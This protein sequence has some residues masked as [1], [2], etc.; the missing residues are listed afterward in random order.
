MKS[1]IYYF[2][3]FCCLSCS[4]L[5]ESDYDLAG[6]EYEET[7]D[8]LI[9]EPN[10]NSIGNGIFF[11]PGGLVD[12][13]AYINTFTAFVREHNMSIIILKVRS[14]LAIINRNQIRNVL[15]DFYSKKWLIG[16]HSLGGSVAAMFDFES[17]DQVLG[18][19]LMASYSTVDLSQSQKPFFSFIGSNDEIATR[20]E[21]VDRKDNLPEGIFINTADDIDEKSTAGKTIYYTIEGGNHSQ[22]GDYG[23]QKKDG[24]ASIS[25]QD[26][27]AEF[28][29]ALTIMMRSNEIIE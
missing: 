18:L 13:H 5:P 12:P 3:L 4:Y 17:E 23:F 1:W 27:K 26:Q 25:E 6:V 9:I 29:E 8:Y 15:D 24:I 14:N 16:G 20:D 21:I 19:F 2:I 11:V 10:S 22:F 7:N 28:Y